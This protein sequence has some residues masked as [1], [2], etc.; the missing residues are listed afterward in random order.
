[1]PSPDV[2]AIDVRGPSGLLEY[3]GRGV[4]AIKPDKKSPPNLV[5]AQKV[6]M[7]AGGTGITPMLQL[8]RQVVRDKGDKTQLKL[9]FANQTEAHIL[10]R[11]EL[12]EVQAHHPDKF[13]LWYTLD[14]PEEGWTYSSGFVNADMISEH[15]YTPSDDT[16]VLMCGPPPMINFAC[17]PNLDK[18]GYSSNMRFAY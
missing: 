5:T 13:K 3:R 7:I 18:L 4:F 15:L 2:L 16:I 12:E 17:I 11:H 9:L 1:M 10:L 6:N 14:R 8:V